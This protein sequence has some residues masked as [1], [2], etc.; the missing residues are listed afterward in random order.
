M[1][2]L[3]RPPEY[4]LHHLAELQTRI[5]DRLRSTLAQSSP[6]SLTSVAA[7][8]EGDTIFA[9]D[10]RAEDLL[11]AYFEEWSRDL[12]IYVVS[13]GFPDD[14]G[15]VYPRNARR[16]RTAFTCVIDPVDGTRVLM[17]QK[18]SAWVL[19][20]IAPPP[21]EA[22]PRLSSI[23]VS[24]QTEIPTLRSH[25]SDRL[26]AVSGQGV[27][28][29]THDL[30]SGTVRP[31]QPRPSTATTLEY[32]FASLSKFFPAH[33]TVTG[34]VEERLFSEVLGVTGG[35]PL[36]FHDQYISTGGQLYELMVGHDRF[37]AD[38]RPVMNA[39]FESGAARALCVHPYDLCTELIAREAGVVVTDER[40]RELDAPL[41][42]RVDCAWAGYA[43]EIIR[44]QVEPVLQWILAQLG[45]I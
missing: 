29:A 12:P 32:G 24:M 30:S 3:P 18:R 17:Y 15:R 37:V 11:D 33:L 14:G 5:R 43:N 7:E 23:C 4:F 42:V 44:R 28:A 27:Q 21:R 41:D 45:E 26:W 25:L 38:V 31:F 8:R 1:W 13:E 19:S 2:S 34:E 6:L 16:E 9:L 22:L 40:G 36:V 39:R 35:N 20:G 10:E